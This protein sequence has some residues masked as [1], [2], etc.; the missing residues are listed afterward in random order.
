MPMQAIRPSR[1]RKLIDI[2]DDVFKTL[3]IKAAAMGTNLKKLIEDILVQEAS[4][5]EDAEVYKYLISTRPE[6]KEMLSAAEQDDFE[7]RMGIG[8]Y[9]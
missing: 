3:T 7:R 9:R 1:H 8:K 6:G 2:P 5:M 4:E